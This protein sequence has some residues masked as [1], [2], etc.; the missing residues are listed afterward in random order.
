MSPTRVI[1]RMLAL[2]GPISFL[3]DLGDEWGQRMYDALLE[4][5]DAVRLM[6]EDDDE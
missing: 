4:A 6:E 3:P 2:V 1:N 5:L